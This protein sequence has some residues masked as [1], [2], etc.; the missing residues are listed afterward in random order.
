MKQ[1]Q[2]NEKQYIRVKDIAEIYSISRSTIYRY[3][4]ANIFPRPRKL[5]NMSFFDR[6]E[7][8]ECF[9]RALH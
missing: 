2:S 7:V 5:G 8:D 4:D 6:N 9:K 1:K 3:I